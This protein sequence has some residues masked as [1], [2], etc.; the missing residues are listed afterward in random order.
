MEELQ[1]SDYFSILK[2]RRN[3]FIAVASVVFVLSV[4]FTLSWSNYRS[5]ATVEVAQS[6]IPDSIATPTGMNAQDM[7]RTLADLRISRLQQR[8]LATGSLVEII[9]KFNLYPTARQS[10]PIAEIA[11]KMRKKIKLQLLGSSL[12]N[13]ASA[14]RVSPDQLSAIAFNLSFDY[15]NPLL[16][17]QVTNDLVSRFLDEDLKERRK[18]AKETSA[19]LETQIKIL[20]ETLKAQEK[21]IA[22]FRAEHGDIRPET[23][24]FNQQIAASAQMSLQNIEGQISANMGL[25]GTLRG[26]LASVDPYS[27]VLAEGQLLTTPTIQLKTLRSNYAE[28]TAKYG[29]S[30]PD[31]LK[32][33]RQMEALEAETGATAGNTPALQATV[34]DVRA[35][36]E[37]AQKTYGSENPEVVSL[38]NQLSKLEGQLAAARNAPFSDDASIKRDADNP[39]YLQIAA[40]LKATEEQYKALLKQKAA[41]QAQQEKYQKAVLANPATEQKMA[42]LTR[43]YDNAQLRYRDLKAKKMSAD[44]V[45]TIEEDRSGQKLVIIN[46]PELPTGTMP[47]KKIFLVGGLAV[48]GMAGLAAVIVAQ[49]LAQSVV[50]PRH[51]ASLVGAAPLVSVPH[52]KT[53]AERNN[54]KIRRLRLA[55]AGTLAFLLLLV[56]FSY[57]VMPLDVL[58]SVL[59]RKAGL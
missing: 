35:R 33:K 4:F 2:R 11:E 1:L 50:G 52:L 32:A 5:E 58:W 21:Q 56:V 39:A 6:E 37:T 28:M 46:P 16:T 27:R 13:P 59:M 14:Q 44:M 53:R 25:Q 10:A 18:Q 30:H 34:T 55:I 49:L 47:S 12:A 8:V 41:L 17:Q 24:A 45:S 42:E 36:L 3:L 40:Q 20:E 15:S 48:S 29:A 51:L 38:R 26:Q 43:D 19:F 54:D 57:V 9:T 22:D 7:L 31:V 23:L